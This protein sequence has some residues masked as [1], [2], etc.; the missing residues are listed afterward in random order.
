MKTITKTFEQLEPDDVIIVPGSPK[1]IWPQFR[2]DHEQIVEKKYD[3]KCVKVKGLGGIAIK[4]DMYKVK[5][6]DHD[7]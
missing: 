5:V 3:D 6:E 2:E 4:M 7:E 1:S